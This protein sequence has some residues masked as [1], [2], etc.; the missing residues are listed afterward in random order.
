MISSVQKIS[1][2]LNCFTKE[3]PA[4]G[5]L[6]IAEKLNMNASTVNHLVRTLCQEGML[7]QDSRKKYRLGWKLLEWSNHVMYQ[8]DIYNEATPF[9]ERL[10]RKFHGTVHI[11]MFDAGEVRFVLKVQSKESLPVPTYIGAT[12]PAY[13][14]S[15][16]KVLL[17]H[18]PALIKPTIAKGLMKLAPNTI[19][20][21]PSLEEEL[22]KI[23]RQGYAISNNENELGLYG[24]AAPIRSYTGQTIAALNMVGPISYMNGRNREDMIKNVVS[25]AENISK[26]LGYISA[27]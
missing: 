3:E 26:D 2:I 20:D 24:I 25:T 14:T 18:N 27:L 7:I 11:G 6:E 12:K 10:I 4:L 8:Q 21:V 16:G 9:C 17:A 1:K 15:T 5:N 22:K 13:C 19:T 23:K